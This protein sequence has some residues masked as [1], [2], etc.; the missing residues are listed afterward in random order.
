MSYVLRITINSI[1]NSL[2][3]HLDC[4]YSTFQVHT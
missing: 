4:D 1:H 2:H 3:K